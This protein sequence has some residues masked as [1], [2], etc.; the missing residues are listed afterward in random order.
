MAERLTAARLHDSAPWVS[1]ASAG[2]YAM[3]DHPIEPDARAML[4]ERGVEDAPFAA[5]DLTA[6]LIEEADLVLGVSREH[7]A[8]VA[9]LAPSGSRKTFTLREFARLAPLVDRTLLTADDPA[10]RARQAVEAVAAKRGY[11]RP[12]SPQDD[13]VPDPY[14]RTAVEFRV[15]AE[16]ISQAVGA[17]VD[18]LT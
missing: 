5:R 11:V 17:V 18:L 2:T 15:A 1:L 8:E 4:T 14:R 12:D 6:A 7:R 13:D 10:E 16:L 9:R 3:V